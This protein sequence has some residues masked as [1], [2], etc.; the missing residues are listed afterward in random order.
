MR[1]FMRNMAV[2]SRLR[3]WVKRL[4]ECLWLSGLSSTCV[5]ENN[6]MISCRCSGKQPALLSLKA[7]DSRERRK[8]FLHGLQNCL[9]FPYFVYGQRLFLIQR[10]DICC[11]KLRCWHDKQICSPLQGFV[12]PL[13]IYFGSGSTADFQGF[14]TSENSNLHPES[15]EVSWKFSPEIWINGRNPGVKWRPEHRKSKTA[16]VPYHQSKL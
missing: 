16:V 12:F 14:L 6:F 5:K 7:P 2:L 4:L 1:D 15:F 3:L 10:R 9:W 8:W 11:D 13:N